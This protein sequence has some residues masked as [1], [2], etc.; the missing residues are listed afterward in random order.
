MDFVSGTPFMTAGTLTDIPGFTSF[1]AFFR[2]RGGSTL[3]FSALGS[4]FV[5]E[6]Q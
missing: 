5:F 1:D 4:D 2:N 3:T 6:R